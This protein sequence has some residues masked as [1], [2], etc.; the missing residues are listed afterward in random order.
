MDSSCLAGTRQ[1]ALTGASQCFHLL[2]EITGLEDALLLLARQD[3]VSG[4]LVGP[5]SNVNNVFCFYNLS[6]GL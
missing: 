6:L 4:D 2:W 1:L 3:L 5:L